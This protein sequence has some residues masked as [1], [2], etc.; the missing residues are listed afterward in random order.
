MASETVS[1]R[2]QRLMSDVKGITS[3]TTDEL[4]GRCEIIV[5]HLSAELFKGLENLNLYVDLTMD[6]VQDEQ[7]WKIAMV[8]KDPELIAILT[9]KTFETDEIAE[10]DED[11]D[12]DEDEDEDEWSYCYGA[13]STKSREYIMSGGSDNWWHYVVEFDEHDEQT[14]VFIT[15]K[16]GCVEQP[17]KRLACRNKDGADLLRL[18]NMD[19]EPDYDNDEGF[20]SYVE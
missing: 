2:I 16:D 1:Q 6:K 11:E 4:T 5:S 7:L 12:D 8:P 19:W 20:V 18:V 14:A 13:K 10:E 17:N 3:N 9:T 15:T